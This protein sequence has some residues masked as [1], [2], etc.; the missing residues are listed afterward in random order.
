MD[1]VRTQA[2][3]MGKSCFAMLQAHGG[4]E[5]Y[6]DLFIAEG[7]CLY[8]RPSDQEDSLSP[9]W[10]VYSDSQGSFARLCR[11][12]LPL[13]SSASPLTCAVQKTLVLINRQMKKFA[14][15]LER[16]SRLFDYL[17]SGRVD[18]QTESAR[19]YLYYIGEPFLYPFFTQEHGQRTSLEERVNKVVSFLTV[20]AQS[21][22]ICPKTLI[23]TLR[24]VFLYF[25]LI[26]FEFTYKRHLPLKAFR[27]LAEGQSLKEEDQKGLTQYAEDTLLLAD[28]PLGRRPFGSERAWHLLHFVHRKLVSSPSLPQSMAFYKGIKRLFLQQ[29]HRGKHFFSSPSPSFQ[30]KIETLVLEGKVIGA[31]GE[32]IVLSHEFA[33]RAALDNKQR[34]FSCQNRLDIVVVFP[35]THP[36]YFFCDFVQET[37]NDNFPVPLLQ[38]LH[39]DTHGRYA[40]FPR[41]TERLDQIAI[42]QEASH[43]DPRQQCCLQALKT[44]CGKLLTTPLDMQLVTAQNLY[45]NTS[46]DSFELVILKPLSTSLLADKQSNYLV[47]ERLLYGFFPHHEMAY[48]QLAVEFGL[49]GPRA[50]KKWAVFFTTS[51]EKILLG[52]PEDH[53]SFLKDVDKEYGDATKRALLVQKAQAERYLKD[54][55]TCLQQRYATDLVEASTLSKA[56]YQQMIEFHRIDGGGVRLFFH[57]PLVSAVA[58]SLQLRLKPEHLSQRAEE[59]K[60]IFLQERQCAIQENVWTPLL[61]GFVAWKEHLCI[62]DFLIPWGY[63]Q[64]ISN[65]EDLLYLVHQLEQ[66]DKGSD[67][68]LPLQEGHRSL[69]T[70]YLGP[71]VA[72]EI[73]RRRVGANAGNIYLLEGDAES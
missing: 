9:G 19:D 66:W 11:R 42:P 57:A 27:L 69:A 48:R 67:T 26:A 62:L 73:F 10:W 70:G 22:A 65:Q 41:L 47:L 60:P 32:E 6:G 38:P 63:T 55:L 12:L 58:V 29:G 3:T 51:L 5:H 49:S 2:D 71:P 45:F 39:L 56:I 1:R 53:E 72:E 7:S 4:A 14:T 33:G 24:I 61:Q 54:Y 64:G 23:K 18:P 37:L 59:L 44:L 20:G 15:E 34:V 35:L 68:P 43:L 50:E 30:E 21:E 28:K 40:I 8:L 31:H 52:A 17:P 36:A 16:A 25:D 46:Q 13:S